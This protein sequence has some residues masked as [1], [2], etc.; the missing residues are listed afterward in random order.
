MCWQRA[1]F[2]DSRHCGAWFHPGLLRQFSAQSGIGG[3]L[4]GAIS[5]GVGVQ[6]DASWVVLEG[7]KTVSSTI[8]IVRRCVTLHLGGLIFMPQMG[9]FLFGAW[10]VILTS[11]Y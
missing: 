4:L 10:C 3:P 9:F 2:V 8:H 11:K 5:N 6:T 7:Q 1:L